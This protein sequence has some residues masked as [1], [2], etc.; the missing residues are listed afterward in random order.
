VGAYRIS[1][2][3]ARSGFPASTLRF[4]EQAGLLP[5]ARSPGGYRLYGDDA[6]DRLGFIAAGKG[7]GLALEEIRELLSVWEHG[8]CAQ[9]R[10]RLRP[11]VA[12]RIEQ[13][14]LRIAE[15]SAFVTALTD[16]HDQLGGQAPDGPCGPG[17]GCISAAPPGPV[18]LEL[19]PTPP[20]RSPT[21]PTP[22]EPPPALRAQDIPVACT[23]TGGEQVQRRAE[24]AD[25]LT[26]ATTHEETPAGVQVGFPL[27]PERAAHLGR[28]VSAEQSCCAFLE[29]TVAFTPTTLVMTITTPP[30]A[31]PVLI[32]LFG[33]PS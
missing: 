15:L 19:G 12:A 33:A 32:D 23:L 2:L 10:T 17:C 13:A 1:E 26:A 8:V 27:D 31:R 24:W 3:A 5:A 21:Q 28:L 30:D 16:V 4:Y 9:V 20:R 22:A 18:L 6:L 29:F 25:L 14:Q 7:L 11:L